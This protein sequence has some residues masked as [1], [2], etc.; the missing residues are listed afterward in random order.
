MQGNHA[1][2]DSTNNALQLLEKASGAGEIQP[3]TQSRDPG[4]LRA[5]W[6]TDH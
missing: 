5:Q 4:V 3:D 6:S 2:S 1:W